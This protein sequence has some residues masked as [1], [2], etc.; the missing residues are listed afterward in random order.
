MSGLSESEIEAI[1]AEA[2]HYEEPSA[3]SIEALKIVQKK[4]SLDFR[5]ELGGYCRGAWHVGGGV[6]RRGDLL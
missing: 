3:A 5:P 6:G 2:G 1:K 4:P